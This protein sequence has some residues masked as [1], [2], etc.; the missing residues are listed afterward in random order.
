MPKKSAMNS[1]FLRHTTNINNDN[2]F[3]YSDI[4]LGAYVDAL[5]ESILKI[6]NIAV[7]F[8]DDTGRSS[9]VSG[10]ACAQFQLTTSLP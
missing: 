6:W 5:G 4:D 1:F 10:E 2:T 3:Q 9:E 7:T 8:S